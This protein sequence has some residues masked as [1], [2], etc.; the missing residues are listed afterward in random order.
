MTRQLVLVAGSGRSGTS[1]FSG[2]LGALGCHIP[3][4]EVEADRTNPYGFG[5]AR[6][7]VDFHQ[8][9]LKQAGVQ[10]T[11]SRP[12]A[13]ARTAKVAFQGDAREQL[14]TWLSDE[15]GKADGRPVVIKDP[16]LLWFIPLWREAGIE[17]DAD[18]SYA[19][20]LRHP[21]SVVHS[22]QTWYGSDRHPSTLAAGWINTMLYTE[23][24]TR[25]SC[26]A[27]VHFDDLLD[28][29]TRAIARAC[30]VLGIDAVD[31]CT[32]GQLR[33]AAK[34][35]DPSLERSATTWEALDVH[36]S[37][38]EL[39][40][41]TWD[42]LNA[43]AKGATDDLGL[44][45]QLD[46]LREHYVQKYEEAEAMAHPAII[47]AGRRRKRKRAPARTGDLSRAKARPSRPP[48]PRSANLGLQV[49]RRIPVEVRHTVPLPLRKALIRLVR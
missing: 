20:L 45:A 12:G 33:Q 40:E 46:D 7:V 43:L 18:V 2:I 15:L 37:I 5:E 25:G 22:K 31:T 4:P 28:D 16:R 49:V 48:R 6:W 14:T 13:F 36:S 11:D 41:Q 44:T 23:R 29:W 34:V 32:T 47:M 3:Q 30:R 19:T 9:L 26:R 1:L 39:A 8:S 38:S 24:A 21:A 17:L 42:A 10:N 35:V 27:F